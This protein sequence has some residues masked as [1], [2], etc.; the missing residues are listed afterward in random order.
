MTFTEGKP[1]KLILRF[2]CITFIGLFVQELYSIVDGIV[3]G[4]FV[5]SNAFTAVGSTVLIISVA[6]T[7]CTGFCG[8]VG[9][10]T[11]RKIGAGTDNMNRYSKNALVVILGIAFVLSA[12]YAVGARGILVL[13]NTPEELLADAYMYLV[14]N[15][16]RINLTMLFGHATS[17][18]QA[19]GDSK[20]PAKFLSAATVTNIALD[21]LFV[22][23]LHMGVAG[24]AVATIFSDLWCSLVFTSLLWRKYGHT[25]PRGAI[26][27]KECFSIFTFAL[28]MGLQSAITSIGGMALQYSLNTLG[29]VYV[30]AASAG[31]KIYHLLSCAYV[32]IGQT[33]SAYCG[34]NSGA[35]KHERVRSGVRFGMAFITIYSIA[36]FIVL[37]F[38][39]NT[40]TLW[41][42]P[43]ATA[44]VVVN[45]RAF[46]MSAA[47]FFI[48]LGTV[49]VLRNSIQGM[50][51]TVVA[52]I[53]GVCE[54]VARAFT[55]FILVP[56][57]GFSAACLGYPLC[58][59][60]ACSFLIPAY[61]ICIRRCYNGGLDT[62]SESGS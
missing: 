55:A 1:A 16:I 45:S 40:M 12:I 44:E 57:F 8:A 49:N 59:I 41:F 39:C 5:G 62:V 13:M 52:S 51:Y 50:G 9:A 28:P 47:T 31:S 11:A 46:A 20:L 2:T 58:W 14:L 23:V 29:T 3:L 60:L 22:G 61:F 10:L 48:P 17:T 54:L 32:A 19:V 18:A 42:M 6:Q 30:A 26:D 43:E 25:V 15:G 4:H 38:A 7:F 24:A 53:N 35:R 34:Q 21:V 27:V 36:S 56:A 33:L 37:Y